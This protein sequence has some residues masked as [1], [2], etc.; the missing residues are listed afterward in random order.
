MDNLH[1]ICMPLFLIL[2]NLNCIFIGYL[3]FDEIIVFML[4]ILNN[5]ILINLNCIF[6]GYLMFDEIIFFM[7]GILNN[8]N[9]WFNLCLMFYE[10][11]PGY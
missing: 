3:M 10:L 5:F 9:W 11:F 1:S 4:G 2:I 6:I 7:L 8:F